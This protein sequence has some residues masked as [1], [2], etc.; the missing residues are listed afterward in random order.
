MTHRLGSHLSAVMMVICSLERLQILKTIFSQSHG[1][2]KKKVHLSACG[3][4]ENIALGFKDGR[5]IKY[6]ISAWATGWK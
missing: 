6:A 2:T 4:E 1:I 3:K 5:A